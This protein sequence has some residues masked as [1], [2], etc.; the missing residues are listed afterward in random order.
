[1]PMYEYNCPVCGNFEVVQKFS[2]EPLTACPSC[3]KDGKQ[4]AV[5]KLISTPSFHVKGSGWYKTDY[6]SGGMSSP[7]KPAATT[8]ASSSEGS[9][10][11]S[12][13]SLKT[14]PSKPCGSG[15]G[16]H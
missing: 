15:C 14:V 7:A 6:S 8:A 5:T 1:M 4:S 3:Q 16:C 12:K 10:S 9:E 13:E 2:D 11:T